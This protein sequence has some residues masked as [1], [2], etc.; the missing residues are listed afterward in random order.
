MTKVRWTNETRKASAL[1]PYPQN[2]KR[3]PPEQ[4][5]LIAASIREFGFGSPALIDSKNML[6]AGHARREAVMLPGMEAFAEAI[7]VRVGH[8]LTKEQKRAFVL[9]DNRLTE[10]GAWD[11]SMLRA[12]ISALDAADFDLGLTGFDLSTLDAPAETEQTRRLGSLA[13]QFGVPPFSV[14]SA[15]D[16]WWQNRK[17]AWLALGIRSEL[18]RGEAIGDKSRVALAESQGCINRFRNKANAVPGGG[19][20]PLDRAKAK[21]ATAAPGGSP[22]P[23]AN[24]K[25]RK[26][27]DGRGREA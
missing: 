17:R 11:Q 23:A 6:L 12:E 16:G 8:G 4:I 9:A 14:L 24:Y 27:G 25:N 26:R 19:P 22:M 21:R 2:A 1:K 18:G 20:M 3:H 7:P 13:E 10:L 5:E 15:R